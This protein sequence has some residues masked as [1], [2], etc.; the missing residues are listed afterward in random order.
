MDFS[1]IFRFVAALAFIIGLIGLCAMVAKRFGLA[2]GITSAGA[3]RRVG[4]VEVRPVDAKHR[5]LLIRRDGKEHLVLIG[6]EHPLLI[7]SGIDAP[8]APAAATETDAP[9]PA[10]TGPAHIVQLQR[11][12]E[13]IKE[14]RA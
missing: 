2:P 9:R 13:Y 7:E 5:L 4:I 1:E 6:G 14:R 11:F 3:N 10:F 12:V 8:A